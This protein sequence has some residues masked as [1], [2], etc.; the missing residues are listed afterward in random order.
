[1]A[2]LAQNTTPPT[3]PDDWRSALYFGRVTHRRQRPVEHA[4]DYG[5]FSLLLDLDELPAIAARLKR[6]SRGRFNLFSFYDRDYASGRPHDLASHIRSLLAGAGIDGS[7]PVQLLCYPRILGYAFNPLAVYY[8]HDGAGQ[9]SAVIYE[10]SNT[11]GERHAYLIPVAQPG[12]VRQ[13][14]DKRL[15]VSPFMPMDQRYHFRIAAPGDR[16]TLVIRQTDADGVIFTA[17][18]AGTRQPL[19]DTALTGAL[20]RHPLMAVKVIGAIHVEAARLMMKGLRL[21]A[22]DPPP[23][24]PVTIILP[25]QL[26][27]TATG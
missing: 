22:G 7:G 5:V 16:L 21:R 19:S 18:F 9:L 23:R 2:R 8:C 4:F 20:R 17:A 14:A 26:A 27:G 12:V 6:F 1:M 11:F 13:V 10:V 24:E 15:H 25:A 3:G